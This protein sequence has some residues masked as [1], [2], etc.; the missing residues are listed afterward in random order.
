M[1]IYNIKLN[2]CISP[3]TAM[4]L[5]ARFRAIHLFRAEGDSEACFIFPAWHLLSL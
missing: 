3:Q 1:V 2:S 4:S 5:M